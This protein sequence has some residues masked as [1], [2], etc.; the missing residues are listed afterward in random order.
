MNSLFETFLIDIDGDKIKVDE[1]QST[2][3][4]I[5]TMAEMLGTSKTTA[6][7]TVAE[8]TQAAE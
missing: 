2:K 5:D 6:E 1:A 7:E 4:I 8:E 3:Q